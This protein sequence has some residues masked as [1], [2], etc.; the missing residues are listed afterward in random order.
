VQRSTLQD[1]FVAGFERYAAGR[2]L[3]SREVEA[4]RC[5]SQCY[6]PALGTHLE[7]C[8][9]GDYWRVQYHACRHR[10]C[11]RCARDARE[12]WLAAQLRRLLPCA[13]AHVIFTLPHTL[14]RLWE[15]NRSRFIALLFASTREA[16]L[17]LMRDSQR[18][19][20]TPGILMNLH[21]W[22]R[23]LSYHP[24]MHCLVSAGGIDPQGQWKACTSKWI[25]P[26][27]PLEILYRNK[28]LDGLREAL[29]GEELALPPGST[30]QYWMEEFGR[31]SRQRWNVRV[32]PAYEHGRGVAQYL[33]RYAKG[34]PMP[35]SKIVQCDGQRVRLRYKDHRR[36]KRRWLQLPLQQFIERVLWHAP[37]R[38]VHVTRHAGLYSTPW[39]EQHA[40][41]VRQLAPPAVPPAVAPAVP[42]AAPEACPV[43][44]P[45]WSPQPTQQSKRCPRC[46]GPLLRYFL[47][48]PALRSAFSRRA[49]A[50]NSK[51][52]AVVAQPA[53]GPPGATVGQARKGAHSAGERCPTSRSS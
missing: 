35:E 33:A 27:K 38:G 5:I 28:V 40:S 14:L 45:P 53:T 50:E 29:R 30:A 52:A 42:A 4:A 31:Q 10:L 3:H 19:G 17:Q 2:Q 22:G 20:V 13:H 48:R 8:L 7:S 36:G 39:R 1:V 16:V 21:T 18:A 15:F 25:L 41:A 26:F 6:T 51:A 49:Q 9:A 34:G 32:C 12:Q 47:R 23:N 37:P 11:P 44:E 24:H 43:T 46:G